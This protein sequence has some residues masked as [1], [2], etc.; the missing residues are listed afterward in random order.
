[1]ST[2]LTSSLCQFLEET[3]QYLFPTVQNLK[4]G[5]YESEI[6]DVK[7]SV[8]ETETLE[9]LDFYHALSDSSGAKTY[10]RFRYYIKELSDLARKMMKYPAVKTWEDAIGLQEEVTI[11]PKPFGNYMRIA[12]RCALNSSSFDATSA[13]SAPSSSNGVQVNSSSKKSGLTRSKRTTL[14]NKSCTAAQRASLVSEDD[15]DDDF[16]DMLEDGDDEI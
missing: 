11:V 7:A 2:I 4:A 12:E 16:E 8:S 5:I 1:M 10:Y 9:S 14:G 13:V 6:L 3:P 15:E